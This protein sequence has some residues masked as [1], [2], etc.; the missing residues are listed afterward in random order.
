LSRYPSPPP[1]SRLQQNLLFA[2][3]T[4]VLLAYFLPWLPHP[5]AGLRLIGLEMG[6]WVKFLP[7]VRSG[8]IGASRDWFYLPPVTLGLA[9]ALL[10]CHWPNGRWQTWA[11]R[12]LALLVSLLAFPAIEAIRLESADHYLFRLQL[13]GL[14]AA[15]AALSSL[16]RYWSPFFTWLLLIA[17]GLVGAAVPT[18][19]FLVMRPAIA[20]VL[21]T[22]VAAGPGVWLNLVGHG[23]VAAVG[24]SLLW[25]SR[26]QTK[27]TM[28][29]SAGIVSPH[30]E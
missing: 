27:K 29:Q 15:V 8:E 16:G 26:Q 11:M 14:A 21:A 28:P 20:Q 19:I 10:T 6:E 12:A 5:A 25:R 3:L 22:G 23:L 18:W 30:Y 1:L 13:V 24:L 4:A 9:L 2:G 7:Q 17:V